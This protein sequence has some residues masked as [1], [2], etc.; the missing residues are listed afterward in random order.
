MAEYTLK[1]EDANKTLEVNDEN[2]NNTVKIIVPEH[3]NSPIPIGTEIKVY[4]GNEAKAEFEPQNSVEIVSARKEIYAPTFFIRKYGEAQIRKRALNQWVLKGDLFYGIFAEGGDEVFVIEQDGILYRVH[5]FTT[6]GESEFDVTLGSGEVECL[7]VAGGGGGGS[8]R[9]PTASS[10]GDRMG[11]GGGAGGLVFVPGL[12]ATV[13]T[14][15]VTV[16]QGGTAGNFS[17]GTDAGRAG[18]PGGDSS[19]LTVT[20]RGGGRGGMARTQDTA[21]SIDGGSGGGSSHN[22]I[23]DGGAGIQPNEAAPSGTP[24]G[25]GNKGGSG[26]LNVSS[27]GGGG[28]GGAGGAGGD[29][30][31]S[32][33]GGAGGVGLAQVV[34]GGVTYRFVDEFPIGVGEALGGE[35]YFA[36]GGGGGR[37][38]S[39]AQGI[40]GLGG[41]GNGGP[42]N[43]SDGLPGTPN[44]GGGGG[45]GSG[46]SDAVNSGAAGGSGIVIVRYRIG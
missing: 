20:A 4:R 35:R 12:T 21:L 22:A 44:T 2:P 29:S 34:I 6:V 38:A 25:F 11:A 8:G 46:D 39:G 45:G 19:V 16:G 32:Q 37:R 15:T 27:H 26:T 9:S 42:N 23:R 33:R 1:P 36:G 31:G 10:S 17:A 24:N 5:T 18:G 28:G 41:G 3:S 14:H 43:P 40:G 13:G 7:V 30:D